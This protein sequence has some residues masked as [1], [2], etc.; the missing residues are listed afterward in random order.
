MAQRASQQ[1]A[2]Q[3][4][5][6]PAEG[7]LNAASGEYEQVGLYHTVAVSAIAVNTAQGNE[8]TGQQALLS[9]SKSDAE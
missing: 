6:L 3:P 1:K 8:N 9:S 7:Q 4:I 5:I 2:Y